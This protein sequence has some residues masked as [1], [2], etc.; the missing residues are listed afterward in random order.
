M[1]IA[2][3]A[4]ENAPSASMVRGGA[5]VHRNAARLLPW[6]SSCLGSWALADARASESGAGIRSSQLPHPP[7]RGLWRARPR[8]AAP[9]P[10][11][12]AV[13]LRAPAWIKRLVTHRGVRVQRIHGGA[14]RRSG[15]LPNCSLLLRADCWINVSFSNI[16]PVSCAGW[17]HRAAGM[18]RGAASSFTCLRGE[19]ARGSDGGGLALRLPIR[20][21]LMR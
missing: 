20:V 6:R 15:E 14:W 9:T 21:C 11:G 2:C 17:A 10:A 4:Y 7:A 3:V 12:Y 5:P 18:R 19:G 8:T 1:P 13:T 16:L